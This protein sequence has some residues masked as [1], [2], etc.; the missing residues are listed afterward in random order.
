VI[1]DQLKLWAD[2][3]RVL[4]NI[5]A[6]ATNDTVTIDDAREAMDF[7][8]AILENVYDLGPSSSSLSH[9]AHPLLN[10]KLSS[11]G[12]QRV[13]PNPSLERTP[14]GEALSSNV[15]QIDGEAR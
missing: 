14:T 5:A 6:H 7:M 15:R 13:R 10:S 9:V 1:S 4:R 11:L 8:K 2:Q 12:W 3:L